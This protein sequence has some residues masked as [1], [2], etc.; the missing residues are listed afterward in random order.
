MLTNVKETII[1]KVVCQ[2]DKKIEDLQHWSI[3]KAGFD[4]EKNTKYGRSNEIFYIKEN[5][6]DAG[7]IYELKVELQG[8]TKT[9]T[10]IMI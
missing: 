4:Y 3:N 10:L 6:L 5:V 8:K 1:F 7:E 9:I 2:N